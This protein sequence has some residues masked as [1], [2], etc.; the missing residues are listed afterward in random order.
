MFAR[1]IPDDFSRL[2]SCAGVCIIGVCMFPSIAR[3]IRIRPHTALTLTSQLAGAA[4]AAA[5]LHHTSILQ[6]PVKMAEAAAGDAS[7]KTAFSPKVRQE[8][9]RGRKG[10]VRQAQANERFFARYGLPRAEQLTDRVG[11]IE[12]K[13]FF[14]RKQRRGTNPCC[15]GC[16]LPRAHCRLHC[17]LLALSLRQPRN[18]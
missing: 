17:C 2:L 3:T 18:A 13:T 16:L 4:G 14:F 10:P 1:R 9:A 11:V 5:L 7:T 8:P 6:N 12:C 15:C